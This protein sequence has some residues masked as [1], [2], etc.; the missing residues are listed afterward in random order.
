VELPAVVS[1]YPR[2]T[3]DNGLLEFRALDQVHANTIGR[4]TNRL[5]RS[6]AANPW[7][8]VTAS[9]AGSRLKAVQLDMAETALA[10][11][12]IGRA[13][14]FARAAAEL[15]ET[16]R[17][18]RVLGDA[19]RAAGR[20]D[21]AVEA[22][23]RALRLGPGDRVTLRSL[24]RHYRSVPPSLRPPEFADWSRRLADQGED[25]L[26]NPDEVGFP[27]HSSVSTSSGSVK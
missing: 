22:W 12:H 2:N 17:S 1:G 26:P 16:V 14:A 6:A 11:Q 24:V 27:D 25:P 10:G 18:L 5:R 8:Y 15:G 7:T 3:D 23:Q 13:M 20:S 9:P 21:E 19:L 4:N